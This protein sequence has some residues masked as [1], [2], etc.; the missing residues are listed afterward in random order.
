MVTLLCRQDFDIGFTT[1]SER[2]HLYSVCFTHIHTH[3]RDSGGSKDD[4]SFSIS[5]CMYCPV[6]KCQS[7]AYKS[8]YICSIVHRGSITI[9]SY[10]ISNILKNKLSPNIKKLNTEK[11]NNH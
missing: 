7:G 1:E 8:I 4:F 5:T 11:V 10:R 6:S 9:T 3:K 2:I